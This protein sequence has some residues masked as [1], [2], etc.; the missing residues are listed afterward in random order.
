VRYGR[1]LFGGE[2]DGVA[3]CV[4]LGVIVRADCPAVVAPDMD[5]HVKKSWPKRCLHV[6]P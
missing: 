1:E 3:G 5:P 2:H 4:G 6:V